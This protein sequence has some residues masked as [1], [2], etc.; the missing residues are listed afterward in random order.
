MVET[1]G[2]VEERGHHRIGRMVLPNIIAL[3][4]GAD[5]KNPSLRG[6]ADELHALAR[7]KLTFR[8]LNLLALV[9]DATC[10]SV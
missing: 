5:L 10:V 3:R 8:L 2:R 9:N 1:E 4:F 7:H 6:L